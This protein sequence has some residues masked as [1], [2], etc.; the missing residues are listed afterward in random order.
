MTEASTQ[1]RGGRVVL[2]DPRGRTWSHVPVPAT[3]A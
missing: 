3:D 1:I 2:V